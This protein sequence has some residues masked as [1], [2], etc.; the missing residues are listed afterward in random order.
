M[1]A[2]DKERSPGDNLPTPFSTP[3]FFHTPCRGQ[4][5]TLPMPPDPPGQG[6]TPPG[7]ALPKV[8]VFSAGHPYLSRL[9]PPPTQRPPAAPPDHSDRISSFFRIRIR[10]L[11][12]FLEPNRPG[13]VPQHTPKPTDYRPPSIHRQS[14]SIFPRPGP[15]AQRTKPY[16]PPPLP[17]ARLD[18]LPPDRS[19]R[20]TRSLSKI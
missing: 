20:T 13:Q 2:P 14:F 18:S 16:A 5:N 8:G 3:P 17:A 4:N 7:V 19:D 9:L 10:H 11:Q 15:T 1:E 6:A 12:P